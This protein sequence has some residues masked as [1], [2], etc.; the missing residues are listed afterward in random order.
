MHKSF[1]SARFLW[2]YVCASAWAEFRKWGRKMAIGIAISFAITLAQYWL[3]LFAPGT[4]PL[5]WL[6]ICGP[7]IVL[8]AVSYLVHVYLA[9]WKLDQARWLYI[10]RLHALLD[11][12]MAAGRFEVLAD[13]ADQLRVDIMQMATLLRTMS[14]SDLQLNH[15]LNKHR[16]DLDHAYGTHR[17]RAWKYRSPLLNEAL[18]SEVLD[19]Y[20]QLPNRDLDELMQILDRHKFALKSLSEALSRRPVNSSS[21]PM[22][23]ALPNLSGIESGNENS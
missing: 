14:P 23:N 16:S 15:H 19:Q 2:G 7:Y 4:M 22:L 12:F 17:M 11:D 8:F 20:T 1:R 9:I 18:R 21:R 10:S 6:G 13:E 5:R 3:G